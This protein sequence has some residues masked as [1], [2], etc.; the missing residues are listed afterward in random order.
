LKEVSNLEDL[1]L[2]TGLCGLKLAT[3][4]FLRQELQGSSADIARVSDT[5]QAHQALEIPVPGFNGEDFVI[6]R[7]W[8]TGV[9]G[10]Q[11]GQGRSD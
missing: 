2:R 4:T 10:I 3:E 8:C 6:H 5:I 9:E 1:A 7:A 11:G